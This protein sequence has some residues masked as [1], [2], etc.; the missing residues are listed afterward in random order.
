MRSEAKNSLQ[1]TMYRPGILSNNFGTKLAREHLWEIVCRC[2]VISHTAIYDGNTCMKTIQYLH[3]AFL[4]QCFMMF[5]N[6][7]NLLDVFI[8]CTLIITFFLHKEILILSWYIVHTV[9]LPK[10]LS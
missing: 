5:G 1:N 9:V 4:Q 2:G 8:A 7:V 6:L 10:K 3:L